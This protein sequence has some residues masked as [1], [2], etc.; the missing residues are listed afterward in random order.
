MCLYPTKWPLMRGE[1]TAQRRTKPLRMGL[2]TAWLSGQAVAVEFDAGLLRE[3]TSVDL[4][5]Y[6]REALV[7]E[8][9]YTLDVTLNQRWLGRLA[10]PLRQLA[11]NAN[12]APCYSKSLLQRLGIDL[13]RLGSDAQHR[14]VGEEACAGLDTL[15]PGASETL[16]FANLQLSLEVAQQALLRQPSGYL[17]PES[18]DSGVAVGFLDYRLNL[19]QQQDLAQ[20]D[21]IRQAYLGVRAGLN[22]GRWYWR[23]EGSWQAAAGMAPA[24][25]PTS[26]SVRRD[27]L[28]WSAQLTLG[29]SYS[30]AQVFDGTAMRGVLVGSDERMLPE[31]Q[32]GFAPVVRGFANSTALLTIRQRGVLLHE[33]TVP[34]GPFEIDQLYASGM[35]DDLEVSLRE[36]DGSTR[37]T[38]QPYGAAALALRPGASRFELGSGVWREAQGRLGPGFLQGNW[39][40]GLDN[41]LS[42]H[43]GAW[44]GEDYL[45]SAMGVAMNTSLG[46]IGVTRV[47]TRAILAA[48]QQAQGQ[49]WRLRWRQR[50][51]HWGTDLSANLTRATGPGYYSFNDYARARRGAR[52]DPLHWSVGV[53]LDQ[54]LGERAGRLRL[55]TTSRRTWSNRGGY[56]SYGIG[57]SNTVGVLGYGVDLNRD[58]RDR[59]RPVSSLVVN[60]SMPFGT[61]R[62]SSLSSQYTQNSQ[63]QSTGNVRLSGIHGDQDQWGYGLSLVRQAGGQPA[64]HG[65]DANLLHRGA[66]GELSGAL[67]SR[68]GYRQAALGAQ[69]ALVAHSGGVI[70]APPLGE[71]FAIVHAP[72][73]KAARAHQHPH[74]R[75]NA[76][77]FAVVPSLLPYSVNT[78]ELDPKGMSRDVELQLSA[79]SVVPRAGAGVLLRYP[80]V[81]GRPITLQARQEGGAALP[82]GA[83]VA[84]EQGNEVGMVGQGSRLHVRTQAAHGQ[85]S[86]IWGK[87]SDTQCWVDY[88]TQLEEPA[89]CQRSG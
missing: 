45:A 10:V 54:Q 19:Y 3:G 68:P 6:E 67:S 60:A 41:R 21:R 69:G 50:L 23:H 31:E 76:Q 73:A 36:A 48:G 46:A 14:L 8:G 82:F 34:P 2:V 32:R 85:L 52:S 42:I 78:V 70:T 75:L 26:T 30:S 43:G 51:G 4:R 74:V 39:Q 65:F 71:S 7:P 83:L 81:T 80:T 13:Q 49:A 38:F 88:G 72:G 55:T 11:Q 18:W 77:G 62:R 15:V 12:A 47:Q 63:G 59:G 58:L 29:D 16:D 79:Q 17:P 61:R 22:T 87:S 37:T 53:S 25:Q 64:A 89:V 84:D 44:L 57:Y 66:S 9:S 5:R 33:S 20:G 1:R 40:Q 35:S 27:I 86:V 24:Y 28:A 56:T